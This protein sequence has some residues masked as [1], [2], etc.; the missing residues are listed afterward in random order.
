MIKVDIGKSFLVDVEIIG[1][2][3]LL[4][5]FRKHYKEYLSGI[6]QRNRIDP[7]AVMS[8]SELNRELENS[9]VTSIPKQLSTETENEYHSRLRQVSLSFMQTMIV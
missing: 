4:L 7:A 9:G 3:F 6:I 1:I 5:N 8:L 2:G